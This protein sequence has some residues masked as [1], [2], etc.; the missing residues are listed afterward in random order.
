MKEC[1]SKSISRLR[2]RDFDK[3]K[4]IG[5]ESKI[6]RSNRCFLISINKSI[7]LGTGLKQGEKIFCYL[8]EDEN[9]R[10]ILVAYL[11]SKPRF[12]EDE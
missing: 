8:L 2:I 11:D 10:P 1:I 5:W 9:S 12:R 4:L 6:R 7:I 3:I